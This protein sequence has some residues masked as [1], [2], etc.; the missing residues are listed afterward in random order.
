MAGSRG[1]SSGLVSEQRLVVDRL[2]EAFNARRFDA[3]PELLGE[4]VLLVM[5][6][7]SLRGAAAL[8][9][10]IASAVRELPGVRVQL[11]RVLADSG[12]TIVDQ[13]RYFDVSSTP[14]S[15][16]TV[17]GAWRLPV[18]MCAVYRIAGGR[19]VECRNYVDAVLPGREVAPW[20]GVAR[21][22]GEQAALRRVATLVAY[23]A[24]QSEVFDAIVSEAAQL[25]GEETW[26]VPTGPMTRR[27]WSPRTACRTSAS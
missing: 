13:V 6:G 3:Y 20:P 24:K 7:R 4:D 23:G 16:H 11:E 8:S 26:L 21:L 1:V 19:I 12:D 18:T 17:W 9:E 2:Y 14:G 5:N 15:E 10:W 27:R 22:V 25:L